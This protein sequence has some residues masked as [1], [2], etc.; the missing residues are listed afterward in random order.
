M[1]QHA[2]GPTL[3]RGCHVVSAMLAEDIEPTAG[4]GAGGKPNCFDP[5][6]HQGGNCVGEAMF[7]YKTRFNGSD[8]FFQ[9]EYSTTRLGSYSPGPCVFVCTTPAK[10]SLGVPG[11]EFGAPVRS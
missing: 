5:E 7:L 1:L 3:W 2:L 10:K 11:R 4:D 9:Q 6:D 8:R